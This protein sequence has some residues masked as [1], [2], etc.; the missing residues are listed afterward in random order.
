MIV[1]GRPG[2]MPATEHVITRSDSDVVISHVT[3]TCNSAFVTP[4]EAGVQSS[5]SNRQHLRILNLVLDSCLRRNDAKLAP[6]MLESIFSTDKPHTVPGRLR[7]CT[8][9]Y[10]LMPYF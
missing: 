4:A 10:F 7:R 8:Y 2:G 5:H 6:G 9:S 1:A 3:L